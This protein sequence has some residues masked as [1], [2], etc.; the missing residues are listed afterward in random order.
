M[1]IVY[2]MQTRGLGVVNGELIK[3]RNTRDNVGKSVDLLLREAVVEAITEEADRARDYYA[4]RDRLGDAWEAF[5]MALCTPVLLAWAAVLE[6][7][8]NPA[9]VVRGWFRS[10]PKPLSSKYLGGWF[11]KQCGH[12]NPGEDSPCGTRTRCSRC[13]EWR[14]SRIVSRNQWAC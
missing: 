12:D 3:T 8:G 10:E 4:A 2:H 9:R 11:C 6:F 14:S 13:G 1:N 7:I 5:V